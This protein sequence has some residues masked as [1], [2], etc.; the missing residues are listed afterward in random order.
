MAKRKFAK[1]FH[2]Y[3]MGINMSK[4]DISDNLIDFSKN[5]LVIIFAIF[6]FASG[7][8]LGTNNICVKIIYV[9]SLV[10][11][12]LSMSFGFQGALVKINYFLNL[13]STESVSKINLPLG[14]LKELRN[15]VRIQYWFSTLS[16]ILLILAICI[17]FYTDNYVTVLLRN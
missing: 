6:A 14:K 10:L 2:E 3:L 5:L 16:L 8:L 9:L 4:N 1:K 15:K 12:L 11:A 17:H 7:S 13:E